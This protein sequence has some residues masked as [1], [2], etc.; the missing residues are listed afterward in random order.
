MTR[1]KKVLLAVGL[2]LV[3]L[4]GAV[5]VLPALLWGDGVDYSTASSIKASDTYQSPALL[6]RAWALPVAQRYRAGLHFQENGS[7]CGP[8]S[9]EN[10]MRSWGLPAEQSAMLEGTGIDT[11][12][13]VLPGGIT[14]DELAHVAD[15]RL[16]KK[17][18]VAR[19]LDLA[20]F[21]ALIAR[22]NDERARLIVNF[23]RGPLF[24]TGGGHHSP[25]AGYLAD[26]DLVFVL[27]VNEKYQPWLVKTER[28]F[29]AVDTVDPS[30]GK[31]RGVLLLED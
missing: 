31:K 19:D 9:V 24:A 20:S 27:D 13:G 5:A 29:A 18:T 1:T 3:L 14:L 4:G 6:E 28:L 11:I 21:R 25:V 2:V 10:V 12:F 22:S 23:H 26:E 15:T 30:S 17:V 8:T 16:D 7:V